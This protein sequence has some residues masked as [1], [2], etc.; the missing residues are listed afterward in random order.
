M[1]SR[2]TDMFS[3]LYYIKAPSSK[4]GLSRQ[5]FTG[6]AAVAGDEILKPLSLRLLD[7]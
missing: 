4:V 2:V 6:K 1:H 5:L 7:G 3:A